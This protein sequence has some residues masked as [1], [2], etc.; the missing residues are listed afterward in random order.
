MPHV[1]GNYRNTSCLVLV[2]PHLTDT[3]THT[4]TR[5]S[6]IALAAGAGARASPDTSAAALLPASDIDAWARSDARARVPNDSTQTPSSDD[7]SYESGQTNCKHHAP[8]TY[9]LPVRANGAEIETFEC[10][11][12]SRGPAHSTATR[13]GVAGRRGEAT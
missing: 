2:Q 10:K 4:N 7:W 8:I 1:V 13:A 3:H 12:C 5:T 11:Y 9:P 6:G